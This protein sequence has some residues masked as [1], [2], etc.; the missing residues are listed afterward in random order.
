MISNSNNSL[1]ELSDDLLDWQPKFT[2]IHGLHVWP[3]DRTNK[4]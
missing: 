1:F 2:N 3:I 4:L